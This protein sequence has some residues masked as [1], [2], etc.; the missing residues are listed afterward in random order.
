MLGQQFLRFW[1]QDSALFKM[2]EDLEE[3]LF[4][5]VM[6]IDIYHIKNKTQNF[7]ALSGHTT[8][9]APPRVQQ[10]DSS[11]NSIA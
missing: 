1:P 7:H 5:W 10:P 4:M 11:L 2:I 8:L 3:F 9:P 6:S